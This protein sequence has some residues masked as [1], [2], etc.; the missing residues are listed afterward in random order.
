MVGSASGADAACSSIEECT[1]DR[2][3]QMIVFTRVATSLVLAIPPTFAWG[4]LRYPWLAVAVAVC[5]FVEANV[6]RLRLRK[7]GTARDRTT[8]GID[9]GFCLILMVVGSRA[10]EPAGRTTLMT[11]L[12][13]FALVC[14]A[15]LGFG[16][17]RLWHAAVLLS[18]LGGAWAATLYPNYTVKLA[19]DLLG[20][21]LWFVVAYL[22]AR[23]LRELA[24]GAA[25]AQ[26]EASRFERELAAREREAAVEGE[27]A[28][29]HREI[30]DYLLPVVQ[31]VAVERTDLPVRE[32]AR[33]ALARVHRFL[34]AE[35]PAND[36]F[37]A[38]ADE[39]KVA[40]PE[41]VAVLEIEH[42]P[43]ADLGAAVLAATREALNN[44]R[45]HGGGPTHLYMRST[46]DELVVSVRDRGPGFDPATVRANG[47]L[48]RTF[49]AV[50][51]LGGSV[52]ISSAAGT[53]V[54]LQWSAP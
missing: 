31:Q 2:M 4:S 14:S 6:V 16:L 42:D 50:E 18:L 30:H 24:R 43:P 28:A 35:D 25:M 41:A 45:K 34:A 53:K 20:F 52:D 23:E 22:I 3:A 29:A 8:L 26:E 5:G 32:A 13:P 12:L 38:S 48:G 33:Q 9:V 37:A 39:L 1:E 46:A 47:G 7:I 49:P 54:V 11:V 17:R 21:A 27:R 36:G 19:S 40:F 15:L 51:R 44:A 10:A